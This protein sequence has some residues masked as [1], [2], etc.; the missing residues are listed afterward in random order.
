[1]LCKAQKK[2][3][4]DESAGLRLAWGLLCTAG[5]MQPRH[6]GVPRESTERE[7]HHPWH[8]RLDTHTTGSCSFLQV[9]CQGSS[10]ALSLKMPKVSCVFWRCFRDL[11]PIPA[12]FLPLGI[13]ST[14]LGADATRLPI[15]CRGCLPGCWSQAGFGYWE[16]MV[17]AR[18]SLLGATRL[19][20]HLTYPGDYRH[21]WPNWGKRKHLD[22]FILG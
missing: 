3:W 4:T 15:Q 12:F 6:L 2:I 18:S 22:L 7:S 21:Q 8:P 11:S 9:L 16:G 17:W 14:L 19:L 10:F 20:P 13:H 1:M 5:Q